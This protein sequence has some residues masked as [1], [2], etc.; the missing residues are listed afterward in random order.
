MRIN[1]ATA[2]LLG[3]LITIG[4]VVIVVGITGAIGLLELPVVNRGAAVVMLAVGGAML[5]FLILYKS[6]T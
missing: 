4:A 5:A 2:S 1:V 6:H 3:L